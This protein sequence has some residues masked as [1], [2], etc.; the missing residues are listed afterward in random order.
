[1]VPSGPR[2]EIVGA[3]LG[4]WL[5]H[6]YWTSR[7]NNHNDCTSIDTGVAGTGRSPACE[8]SPTQWKMSVTMALR[9]TAS[10]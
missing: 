2:P 3:A 5:F 6:V 10:C 4:R 7:T 9:V 1:M 8:P